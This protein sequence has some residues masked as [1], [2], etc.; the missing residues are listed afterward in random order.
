MDYIKS[1]IISVNIPR[2]FPRLWET[3][4]RRMRRCEV[5]GINS[6]N[7]FL[8]DENIHGFSEPGKILGTALLREDHYMW[9]KLK[10][11]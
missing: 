8:K 7:N 4:V 1:N 2:E 9:I 10:W 6:F 5:M 3:Y 11:Q